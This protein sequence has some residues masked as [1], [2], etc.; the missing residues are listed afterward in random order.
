MEIFT[1]WFIS[2]GANQLLHM[3]NQLSSITTFS[4]IEFIKYF[5]NTELKSLDLQF[6]DETRQKVRLAYVSI[7]V[8]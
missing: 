7:Y 1:D 8:S 3:V 5:L 4:G 6:L 2:V